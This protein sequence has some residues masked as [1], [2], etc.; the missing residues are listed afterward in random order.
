MCVCSA[1]EMS[2]LSWCEG[3]VTLDNQFLTP[4]CTN[5]SGR[6]IGNWKCY[7]DKIKQR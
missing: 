1:I 2:A 3:L 7:H 4:S 5:L 6:C